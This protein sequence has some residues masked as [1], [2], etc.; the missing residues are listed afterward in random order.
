MPGHLFV[1]QKILMLF[2]Q[3]PRPIFSVGISGPGITTVSDSCYHLATGVDWKE[4]S[5]PVNHFGY[6]PHCHVASLGQAE[7]ASHLTGEEMEAGANL[8]RRCGLQGT[9]PPWEP[10][11]ALLTS[12]QLLLSCTDRKKPA[13]EGKHCP[14]SILSRANE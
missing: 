5:F 11:A 14:L 3:Y 2:T 8:C 1:L 10:H 7:D 4:I 12:G 6:S 9:L 13:S